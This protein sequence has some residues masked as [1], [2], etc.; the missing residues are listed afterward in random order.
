[1]TS[2]GSEFGRGYAYCMIN[3]IHK[4]QVADVVIFILVDDPK[5]LLPL[6]TQDDVFHALKFR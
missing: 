1:M 5:V 2:L 3:L 4:D 6:L